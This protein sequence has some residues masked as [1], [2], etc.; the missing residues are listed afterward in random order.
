MKC[1]I[2]YLFSSRKILFLSFFLLYSH[3][4]Y[5][6]SLTAEQIYKKVS[7]AVV[8]IHAYNDNDE[9]AAQGSGVVLNDK[10][11]VVTNYHVLSGNSKLK[12]LHGEE[13]VPYVDI[14]GIDVEKDI[15][16]LKIEAKK[17]P[18]IKV[19]DSKSL[20][21]GQRVYSIGSPMGLENS[22]SE[23]ILSGLRSM[24]E[25]NR[26][27]IQITA[28]ISQGS[29]GGAIVNNKGE[30]IGISTLTTKEGQNLNFAIPI[31]DILKVEIG[32]YSK[33]NAYKDFE[34][35]EK[36][37]NAF[38]KGDFYEAIKYLSRFIEIYPTNSA[39]YNNRGLAKNN[40]KDYRGAIQDYN[41]TIELNSNDA[42]AYACRG[43]AK[44]YLEDYSGAIQDFNKAIEINPNEAVTY[45]NRGLSKHYLKDYQRAIQDYN[46]A[47]E[48]DPNYA[49]AFINR[50][51]VKS[52]L[53]DFRGAIQ[54]YNKAIE[55]NPNYAE[56]YSGRGIA[57]F[58]LEDYTG[59]IQDFNK[60]I[61][62]N[63]NDAITYS[64]RGL[65]KGNL[66]D[67]RGAIQDFNKAI[68]FNPSGA[69]IYYNRGIA[70]DAL[71]DIN[72]AC[73]DWSKAGELGV[74]KAYDLI[75]EYCG[76]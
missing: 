22:I 72:G 34:L 42:D 16:I 6:Q 35:F 75:K 59:A 74:S 8:V 13:I 46:K 64:N 5:C 36:A 56:A 27:F 76:K 30:L 12:I 63:P 67:H 50:G 7:G 51:N 4:S 57:K 17:F 68:E 69:L 48:L 14:I 29:S 21:I 40:L 9:L 26:N 19:G 18:A 2:I 52:R 31:E 25:S 73:L 24:E 20:N 47:I 53:E 32:S 49:A 38:K 33:N 44:A 62:L 37:F 66:A 65:A 1:S 3:N 60:T 41:K 11:Y 15:L 54:D 61:E 70:K 28:S 43:L 58:N 23:G 39:A 10:G 55:L 45:Y 71:G